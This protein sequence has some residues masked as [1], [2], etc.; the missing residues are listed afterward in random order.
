[1]VR[2]FGSWREGLIAAGLPVDRPPLSLALQERI[3]AARSMGAQGVSRAEIA[4]ELGV[5]VDVVGKYLRARLCECGESYVVVGRRCNR[6][7][8]RRGPVRAWMR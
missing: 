4:A 2:A 3:A 5:Y 1:V 7:A 8:N 6:W